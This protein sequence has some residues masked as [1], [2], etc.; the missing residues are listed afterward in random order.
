[1]KKKDERNVDHILAIPSD[2]P[3]KIS[4]R[5]VR[6]ERCKTRSAALRSKAKA[7]AMDP[8][9]SGPG[10]TNGSN[11]THQKPGQKSSHGKPGRAAI[12][13]PALLA[14]LAEKA[15]SGPSERDLKRAEQLGSLDKDERKRA[16]ALDAERV[17][18]RIAKKQAKVLAQ[19]AERKQQREGGGGG[20]DKLG[21]ESR[22][23]KRN[24]Q[25][26]KRVRGVNAVKKPV[27]KKK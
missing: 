12:V 11:G 9:K 4:K 1:M 2:R 15:K 5:K 25:E 16:K 8:S 24:R 27:G 21:R 10:S 22:A 20:D 18:R 17:A 6:L 26:K 7:A 23:E 14:S 13:D 3:L 19:V